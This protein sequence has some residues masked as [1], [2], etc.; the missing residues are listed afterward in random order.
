M[1]WCLYTFIDEIAN[2]NAL[3]IWGEIESA[4]AGIA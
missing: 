2:S 4:D 1:A 3:V